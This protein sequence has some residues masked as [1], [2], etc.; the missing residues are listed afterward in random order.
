MIERLQHKYALSRQGAVDMVKAC[1]SVT[2]TNIIFMMSAGILYTL[3]RDLLNNSLDR[4]RIPFYATTSAVV[5]VLIYITNF[6]QYNAT[7]LTTYR[8]SGV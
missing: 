6:I 3:I 2:V 4:S 8:E 1:F 5:L 7:F